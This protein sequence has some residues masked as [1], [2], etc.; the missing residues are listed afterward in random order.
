MPCGAGLTA[1]SL[2]AMREARAEL[3]AP[4]PDRFITD[5]DAPLEQQLRN[6]AQAQ[7]K[8][9]VPAHGAPDDHGRKT[10]TTIERLRFLHRVILRDSHRYVTA[11]SHNTGSITQVRIES[12]VPRM[13]NELPARTG[14]VFSY[15]CRND[16]QE[17]K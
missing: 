12:Y 13:Y 2:N 9:E 5:N 1:S 4:A 7:L 8:P 6:V 15:P 10:V 11:P 17:K 16:H 3:I 14:L